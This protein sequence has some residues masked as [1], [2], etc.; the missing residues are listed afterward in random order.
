MI[1]TS[2]TTTTTTITRSFGLLAVFSGFMMCCVFPQ[3]VVKAIQY[4]ISGVCGFAQIQTIC[5]YNIQYSNTSHITPIHIT[6]THTHTHTHI[7]VHTHSHSHTRIH[8][9]IY[10]YSTIY[11]NDHDMYSNLHSTACSN[12]YKNISSRKNRNQIPSQLSSSR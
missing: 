2:A 4:K 10:I 1:V 11:M 8:I 12:K 9:H 6:H 5:M 7:L 3:L